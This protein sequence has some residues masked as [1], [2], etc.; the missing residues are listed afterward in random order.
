LALDYQQMENVRIELLERGFNP[1]FDSEL[2]N[3]SNSQLM[4]AVRQFQAEYD[5]PVTG[6]IDSPTLA[7][8]SIATQK[9]ALAISEEPVRAKPSR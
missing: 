1:G 5:L 9:P 8:L 6:Q 7:A 2:S 3:A 4:E